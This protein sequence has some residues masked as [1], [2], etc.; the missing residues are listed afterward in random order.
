MATVCARNRYYRRAR[1]SERKFRD[2]VRCFA[3]DLNASDTARL[4]GITTRSVNPIF[5]KLR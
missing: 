1:L 4:T 5:L 3:T 2:I